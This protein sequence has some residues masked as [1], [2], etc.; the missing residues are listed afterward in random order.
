MFVA[1]FLRARGGVQG[2][3]GERRL[4]TSVGVAARLGQAEIIVEHVARE[5]R[6]AYVTVGY[7]VVDRLVVAGGCVVFRIATAVRITAA[8]AR[9]TGRAVVLFH[10]HLLWRRMSIVRRS[11]DRQ[12]AVWSRVPIE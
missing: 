11:L 5:R 1:M 7:S 6:V 12:R 2:G 3:R 4:V 8:V 9:R 10:L